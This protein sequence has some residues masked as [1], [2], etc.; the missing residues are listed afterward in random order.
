MPMPASPA[1]DTIWPW[2]RV[3]SAKRSSRMSTS[4]DRPT[5]GVSPRS[6]AA[7][8]RERRTRAR[9]TS[10]ARAGAR[11]FTATSPRS[12]VSKKLAMAAWVASLTTTLPGRAVC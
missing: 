2:P 7:A 8:S 4:R 11:P 10:N 6:T 12:S 9:S 5:S 3:T 1:R